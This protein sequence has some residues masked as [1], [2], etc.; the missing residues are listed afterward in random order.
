MSKLVS[1]FQARVTEITTRGMGVLSPSSA[2]QEKTIFSWGV[3][4][5]E[6]G[7]FQIIEENNKYAI[8]KP[9]QL[10]KASPHRIPNP[11][12]HQGFNSQSCG[13]CPWIMIDYPAQLEQKQTLIQKK[14]DHLDLKIE[15]NFIFPSD[16]I[17][18][19]RNRTQFKT[20]GKVI[21]Y[22]GFRSHEIIPIKECKI[23]NKK[24]SQKF[25]FL[26]S[27]LPEEEWKPTGKFHFNFI[28]IDDETNERNIILN[29]KRPFKQANSGQNKKMK[30]WIHDLLETKHKS[31]TILE[32]FAGSGNFTQILSKLNF[33]NIIAIESEKSACKN[34]KSIPNTQTLQMD[35]YNSHEWSRIDKFKEKISVILLDPPRIGFEDLSKFIEKFPNL[36]EIIYISCDVESY[37]RD[38][39]SLVQ[40]HWNLKQVQPVDQFPHTPHVEIITHL[41]REIDHE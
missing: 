34:L 33:E 22:N 14:I 38:I 32:L 36:K 19:Y 15:S 40:S 1:N 30:L 35:L 9:V 16:D 41:T 20:N 2:N 12:P 24:L 11:C 31:H 37:F 10:S 29:K 25:K 8:A 6:V 27:C 39:K 18:K 17:F 26:K 4:I 23:L 7:E 5:D 21:G 3:W 28:E 13:G